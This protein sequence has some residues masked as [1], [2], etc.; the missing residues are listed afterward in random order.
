MNAA[1]DRPRIEERVTARSTQ[2]DASVDGACVGHIGGCTT[3]GHYRGRVGNA[4]CTD[5]RRADQAG[6]VDGG[7]AV[8]ILCHQRLSTEAQQR[9]DVDDTLDLSAGVVVDDDRAVVGR[10][11]ADDQAGRGEDDRA[12]IDRA[13]VVDRHVVTGQ[14]CCV[15]AAYDRR[16]TQQCTRVDVQREA[17]GRVGVVVDAGGAVAVYGCGAGARCE[18]RS[19]GQCGGQSRRQ[20]VRPQSRHPPCA[21]RASAGVLGDLRSNLHYPKGTIENQTVNAVHR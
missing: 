11:I 1:T 2:A 18:C 12:R 16:R 14:R 3:I 21:D 5:Q 7:G 13:I 17:V 4:A 9:R 6:V 19:A 10:T 15:A 20:L 8:D